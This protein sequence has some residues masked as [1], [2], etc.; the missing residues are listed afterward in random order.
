MSSS[1]PFTRRWCDT[2]VFYSTYL[3]SE[4]RRRKGRTLLT[5]LGLAVGV[6]L[7]VTVTALSDGLDDAQQK[8]LKPLTGVGTDLSVTR[9]ISIKANPNGGPPQLSAKD[10]AELQKENGSQR[11]DFAS[12]KPGTHFSRTSYLSTNL[13]VSSSKLASIRS[14]HG[15]AAAAGGLTLNLTTISGTIPSSQSQSQSQSGGGF[16]APPSSGSGFS[17]P[18]AINFATTT[19]S[20]VDQTKRSLGAVTAGQISKGSYFTA[21]SKAEAILD[22][23]YARQKNLS[24]GDTLNLA[25][26]KFTVVGIAQTPLGGKSSDVYVK[27]AQLQKLSNRAGRV[28]TVYVRATSAGEVAAVAKRLQAQ[29]PGSSVTTAKTLAAQ[30]SGS[31]VDAKNL[32]SKLGIVLELVGLLGAVLIACL[33]TL[34][35]VTKRVRELGTLKAIGWPKRAVVRQVTGESLVQGALGGLVGVVLGFAGAAVITVLA[36][37]LKA[38]VGSAARNALGGPGPFGQGAVTQASS[39]A[40][41]LTAHVSPTVIALAVAL[42]VA[43]GLV[44]GAVGGLRA[45]RLRPADAFRHID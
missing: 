11:F 30:V 3:F 34:S 19:V 31:L 37:T 23:A 17:G 7:V 12:L 38:T 36:P 6:G 41:S 10:R 29:L 21:G 16:G 40:V 35:S 26:H 33:L 39:Q 1:R 2:S 15:V 9:P 43:G 44:A 4:L 20:G 42:A 18:R 8:V 13:S 25:G 45:A 27:L 28:N 5:A 32:T 14:T 22:V 24:V